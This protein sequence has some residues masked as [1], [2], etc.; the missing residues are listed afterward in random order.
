MAGVD[1]VVHLGKEG[2]VGSAETRSDE[3]L[4]LSAT[5]HWNGCDFTAERLR[6]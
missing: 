1:A 4:F 2:R 6:Y 3:R 5:R